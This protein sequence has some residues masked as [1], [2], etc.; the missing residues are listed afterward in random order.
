MENARLITELRQR[1]HDLQ[2]SLEYQTATSDVL[3]VISQSA[4][5]L[6]PVLETVV[7]TATRICGDANG[8]SSFGCDG[9]AYTA[10]A[11]YGLRPEYRTIR[12]E[13]A[14]AIQ[15]GPDTLVGRTVLERRA[16]AHHRRVDGSRIYQSEARRTLGELRTMLGVP[17]LREG[18]PIGVICL[19]PHDAS[20]RSPKSR[21]RWS[22]PLPT[23]R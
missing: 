20:S 21:S 13:R 1:T 7:E 14:I 22:R 3:K 2:E 19:G 23:R 15:P 11:S 8:R 18:A 5:D 4:F 12:I 9:T 16:G 10:W 6:E 17:L